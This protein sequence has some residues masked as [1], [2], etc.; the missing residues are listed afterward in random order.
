MWPEEMPIKTLFAD[1]S[2]KVIVYLLEL[3]F[4]SFVNKIKS[5]YSSHKIIHIPTHIPT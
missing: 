1:A 3:I 5:T 2:V 4:N